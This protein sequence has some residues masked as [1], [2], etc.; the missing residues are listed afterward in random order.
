MLRKR[1]AAVAASS[2]VKRP[3]RVQLDLSV[4]RMLGMGGFGYVQEVL[5]KQKDMVVAVKSYQQRH[6]DDLASFAQELYVLQ[7]LPHPFIPKFFGAFRDNDG[8]RHLIMQLCKGGDLLTALQQGV[9]TDNFFY[10]VELVS[11]LSYLHDHKLMHS[12][13]KLE[14]VFID[15][16]GHIRLGDYGSSACTE[17]WN[18]GVTGVRGSRAYIAPEMFFQHSYGLAADMWSLGCVLFEL[19]L[20]EGTPPFDP[21]TMTSVATLLHML[22]RVNA[23]DPLVLDLMRKLLDTNPLTRITM[24]EVKAHKLFADVSWEKVKDKTWKQPPWV[25][26]EDYE[27]FD[28][29]FTNMP[30]MPLVPSSVYLV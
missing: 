27:G 11:V 1:K 21:A 19:Y 17:H 2:D 22:P 29:T 4:Q 28:A 7:T 14:N 24:T 23:V 20:H 26:T 18:E 10:V 13:I 5:W 6:A 9:I 12:D 3:A 16:E 25:P 30:V 8:S 15:D